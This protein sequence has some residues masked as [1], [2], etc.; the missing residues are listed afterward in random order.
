[1]NTQPAN[2]AAPAVTIGIPTHN[3]ASRLQRALES[4]VGQSEPD[5]EVI[6]SDDAST[7]ETQQI[8]ERAAVKDDRIRSLRHEVNIGLTAN[9]NTLFA[10]ARGRYVMI[11]ADDDWLEPDYVARCRAA[12]ENDS[13]LALVCGSAVYHASD[14]D[15]FPGRDIVLLDASPTRRVRRYFATVTDNVCLYGLIRKPLIDRVLPMRN[16]LAGDWLL[17]AR[18]AF[19]GTVRT[20]PATYVHRSPEGT[21]ADFNRTVASMRLSRF[22]ERHSH[23]AIMR[24]IRADIARD[25]PVYESLSPPARQALGLLCGLQIVRTRLGSLVIEEVLARPGLRVLR[26]P[27]GRLARSWRS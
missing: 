19:L 13:R 4:A 9:F 14:G 1:L 5:L 17:I 2:A 20:D 24:F 8:V 15:T 16:C 23:V 7:D 25:S 10:A 12:L 3:R 26:G 6:V 27:L 21:S 11:L 18:L 22:E